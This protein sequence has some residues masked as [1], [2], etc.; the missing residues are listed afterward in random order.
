MLGYRKTLRLPGMPFDFHVLG[1]DSA[2]ACGD[3]HD[4]GK[5]WL[6]DE[7]VMQLATEATGNALEGLPSSFRCVTPWTNSRTAP[8]C[9]G[10]SPTGWTWCSAATCTNRKPRRRLN[11]ER[12][13]RQ[14]V[15][16]CLYER[17]GSQCL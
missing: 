15:A 6:T 12:T 8:R 13:L 1:L 3:D 17:D 4:A 11:P 7:Q 2:W 14:V 10:C 9:G 5:L 16:G